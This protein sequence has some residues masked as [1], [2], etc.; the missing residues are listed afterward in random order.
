MYAP[1]CGKL[2]IIAFQKCGVVYVYGNRKDKR[3][4]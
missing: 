3:T 4:A 2:Y 1:S